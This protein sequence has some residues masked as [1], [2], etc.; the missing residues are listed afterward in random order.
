MLAIK[1]KMLNGHRAEV[2]FINL[3]HFSTTD[4]THPISFISTGPNLIQC[5]YCVFWMQKSAGG[6]LGSAVKKLRMRP[7]SR[8]T[9]AWKPLVLWLTL[10]LCNIINSRDSEPE[11]LGLASHEAATAGAYSALKK[12]KKDDGPQKKKLCGPQFKQEIHSLKKMKR[13]QERYVIQFCLEQ[14]SLLRSW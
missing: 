6:V 4:N 7:V 5:P 10:P 13:K 14:M 1:N 8:T 9:I 2:Y 11:A 12:K 3:V